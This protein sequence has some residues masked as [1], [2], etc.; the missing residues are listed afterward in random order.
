MI[1]ARLEM[2]NPRHGAGIIGSDKEIQRA[3]REATSERGRQA[4]RVD[5]M[6]NG[7]LNRRPDIS[8][9]ES[10]VRG[11]GSGLCRQLSHHHRPSIGELLNHC[12]IAVF[13]RYPCISWSK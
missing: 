5:S 12:T 4:R 2:G 3:L 11:N 10:V 8:I 7:R 13:P 6:T 9:A 1:L